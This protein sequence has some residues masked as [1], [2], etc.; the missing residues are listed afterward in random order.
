MAL[1]IKTVVV[2]DNPATLYSTG[3]ILESA[4]YQVLRCTRGSEALE[5]IDETTDVAILDINLPDIDGIEICRRLRSHVDTRQMAIIH[6]TA[7]KV[8][9]SDRV[10]GLDAGA[11]AYLTHPVHPQVLLA[12]VRTLLRTRAAELAARGS[13]LKLR[14]IFDHASCGIAIL[15]RSLC[16]VEANPQMQRLAHRAAQELDRR[17]LGELAASPLDVDAIRSWLRSEQNWVGIIPFPTPGG[18][19]VELEFNLSTRPGGHDVLAIVTDVTARGRL[20]AERERLLDIEREARAE[21]E[22]T[23]RIK[24]E[25]LATLSHELRNPLAPLKNA[26]YLLQHAGHGGA[27]AEN[28]RN[29]MGRQVE[30]MTRLVDDLIDVSRITRGL[31]QLDQ[32]PVTLR[33]VVDAA[34]ETSLPQISAFDHRFSSRVFDEDVA[35][36]A[37]PL[38]LAQVL[39]NILN[40]AA[41]YT[42]RG[43][44]IELEARIVDE[45][46]TIS[47]SDSGI[48]I[49]KPMLDDIFDMFTQ[50]NP[51][52]P[53]A[54]GGLGI[55]LTLVKRLVEMHGGRVS[56][57]SRGADQ[58]SVFVVELPLVR[59]TEPLA[60]VTETPAPILEDGPHSVVVIDDNQDAAIS[61]RDLLVTFGHKCECFFDG[62]SGV[63]GVESIQPDM[64][65]IDIGMP[66][67][68]GHE[69]AR[70]LKASPLTAR[71]PLFALTGWDQAGDRE[72]SLV[73]GFDRHLTKPISLAD[74]QALLGS[75]PPM[76]AS[77]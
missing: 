56:V 73:A 77:S 15:D 71:I 4:S 55:G 28:A 22:R 68:D 13:E 16:F 35:F 8:G 32:Q 52:G 5:V 53:K 51:I 75:T 74:L 39:T 60:V 24:D 30:H 49:P 12:T 34:V 2:D 48:G 23:A 11:D 66:L 72:R 31:V 26:L 6:L 36:M 64:V 9:D 17:P 69:V 20:E 63:R 25:F 41:K 14:N 54:A 42:P 57:S 58:G 21:A 47:I 37:D 43:G 18:G 19:V 45:R 67:V 1:Q 65:F 10:L 40:N 27:A 29:I 62:A 7:S 33:S 59:P 61:L 38:R 76:S 46:I 70:R 3:R 50:I 44:T